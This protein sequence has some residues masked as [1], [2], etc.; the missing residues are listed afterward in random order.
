MRRLLR[1]PVR[2]VRYGNAFN[3]S[4]LNVR[5]VQGRRV[6]LSATPAQGPSAATSHRLENDECN[7]PSAFVPFLLRLAAFATQTTADKPNWFVVAPRRLLN[8]R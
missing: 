5:R 4:V 3:P 8:S 2:V 6:L 1:L 7:A